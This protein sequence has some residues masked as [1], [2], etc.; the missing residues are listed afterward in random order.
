VQNAIAA[1]AY[2]L[3]AIGS[4]DAQDVIWAARQLYE[5]ADYIVQRGAP[6]QTY[7]EDLKQEAPIQLVLRGLT[8]ALGD[9]DTA[10]LTQLQTRA[11]ADGETLLSLYK[12]EGFENPDTPPRGRLRPVSRLKLKTGDVFAVP[13][14]EARVGVGQI[15]ATYGKDAYYFA[16]FDVVA[17]NT[18]SI[19]LD[20]A[21]Q[22][23]VVFLALSLDAK[24]AAGHW[25]VVG[26]RPVREGIPLPAFKE[27][28]GGSGRIDVVDYSGERRRPAKAAEAEL[29]PNRNVVAPVRLEKALRARHGLEPWTE[30]YSD[31]APNET[32]TTE[33]LFH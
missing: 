3:R 9:L 8:S 32:A 6:N 13:I 22:Q 29:L 1:V 20:E 10:S 27:A 17:P 30:A 15:V 4:H 16:I 21:P 31:L 12:G 5:A 24:L 23:G 2:A 26:H 28:V 19:D 7:I 18:A 25:S 33:R 11:R 14:D